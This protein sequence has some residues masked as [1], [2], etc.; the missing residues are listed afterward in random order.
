MKYLT[1]LVFFF[2]L[3]FPN[4]FAGVTVFSGDH[5]FAEDK[6]TFEGEISLIRTSDDEV[7]IMVKSN[8]STVGVRFSGNNYFFGASLAGNLGRYARIEK[9][10]G[11]ISFVLLKKPARPSFLENQNGN[12]EIPPTQEQD[13]SEVTWNG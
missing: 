7:D 2:Y 11:K 6:P 5:H 4:A 12:K 3:S 13:F 8:Y 10:E 9:K 1:A